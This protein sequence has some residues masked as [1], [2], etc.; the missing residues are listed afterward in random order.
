MAKSKGIR[1]VSSTTPHAL[2]HFANW[3]HQDSGLLFDKPA[4]GIEKYLR[5]LP[6]ASRAALH[7]ELS[8]FLDSHDSASDAA[9]R[10]AW[11]RLGAT[12]WSRKID[13]RSLL[14]E[15]LALLAR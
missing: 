8:D 9:L 12:N 4:T 3:F 14:Q 11:Q 13:T 7:A 10:K 1:I 15:A 2:G 6:L 5:S